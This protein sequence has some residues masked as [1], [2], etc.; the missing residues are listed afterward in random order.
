VQGCSARPVGVLFDQIIDPA[1]KLK[2]VNGLGKER[3][4]M[5]LFPSRS[6]QIHSLGLTRK[7]QNLA[8]GASFPNLNGEIDTG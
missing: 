5:A 8:G 1:K 2:W 6:Q 3:K 4:I 7:Q